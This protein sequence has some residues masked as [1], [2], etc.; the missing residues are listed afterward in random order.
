MSVS[1]KFFWGLLVFGLIGTAT[2]LSL[3]K[4]PAPSVEV[5]KTLSPDRFAQ[6]K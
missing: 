2:A 6:K 4:I 3:W 1:I 5:V